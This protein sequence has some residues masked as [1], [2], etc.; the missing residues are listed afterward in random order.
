MIALVVASPSCVA[1]RRQLCEA[2]VNKPFIHSCPTHFLC[3][4]LLLSI[5]L[6]SDDRGMLVLKKTSDYGK[7]SKTIAEKIYSF[8]IGGRFLFAS[9]MTGSVSVTLLFGKQVCD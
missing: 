9:V 3:V 7:T 8:G 4:S 5:F 6:S 2:F 1:L